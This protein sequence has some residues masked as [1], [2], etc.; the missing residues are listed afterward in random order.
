M[1]EKTSLLEVIRSLKVAGSESGRVGVGETGSA[2]TRVR[3]YGVR[4]SAPVPCCLAR[5]EWALSTLSR[6]A[7]QFNYAT[8]ARL[9]GLLKRRSYCVDS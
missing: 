6:Q 8:M 2:G 9:F 7:N 5:E 4:V 3:G 1:R